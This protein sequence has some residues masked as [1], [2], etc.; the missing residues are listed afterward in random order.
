MIGWWAAM[1]ICTELARMVA[2]KDAG[3]RDRDLA[4]GDTEKA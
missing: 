1:E 3:V 4:G 2:G